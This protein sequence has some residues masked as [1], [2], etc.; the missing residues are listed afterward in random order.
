MMMVMIGVGVCQPSATSFDG[1]GRLL[2][3]VAPEV[4]RS[5]FYSPPRIISFSRS[6]VTVSRR[7]LFQSISATLLSFSCLG[8]LIKRVENYS[9]A[10]TRKR[11]I[12]SVSFC[13]LA[14]CERKRLLVES[15][16][17]GNVFSR[18]SSET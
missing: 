15:S 12:H 10:N 17:I 2:P 9:R 5:K 8:S 11:H 14:E 3:E 13:E 18:L 16:H 1:Q 6:S 7:A 4:G